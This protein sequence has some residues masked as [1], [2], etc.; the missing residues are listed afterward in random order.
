MSGNRP[1]NTYVGWLR[2][3]LR[4]LYD[5]DGLRQNPLFRLFGLG[6]GH[7]PSALRSILVAAIKS[8]KPDASVSSKSLAWRTYNILSYRFV[9]Q[10][11]QKEA[12]AN[13]GLSIRQIRRIEARAVRALAD[14]LW[15][16]YSTRTEEVE[17][18]AKHIDEGLLEESPVGGREQELEW[19]DRASP[20][21]PT[22]LTEMVQTALKTAGPLIEATGVRAVCEWPEGLPALSVRPASM[23][24]ALLIVLTAAAQSVPG[25]SISIQAAAGCRRVSLSIRSTGS[26][27]ATSDALPGNRAE[28]LALAQQLTA[29]SGGSLEMCGSPHTECPFAARLSLPTAEQVTV[30]VVDDNADTLQLFQRYLA[31]TR[32]AFVGTRDPEEALALATGRSP[33]IIVLDVMMPGVDG[34]ELLG[35]LREH[36][37]ACAASIIVCTILPQERLA[38]MLGAA[39]F[40]GKPFTRMEL[41]SVLDRQASPRPRRSG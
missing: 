14:A 3:A 19:L 8:L 4:H 28:S 7:S 40:L 41:L 33:H 27:D 38:L 20:S 16:Q 25:G 30:L 36:P 2:Q 29:V 15:S 32:Y 39:A 18:L 12:K 9:E 35:R 23:R 24:Q 1:T 26:S 21:E 17:A 31:G 37:K 13:F 5:P 10:F 34:W 22:D 6:E 11:T